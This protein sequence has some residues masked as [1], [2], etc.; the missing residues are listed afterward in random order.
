MKTVPY[1]Q[2][3]S[4]Y[5]L[6]QC[7]FVYFRYTFFYDFVYFKY[8]KCAWGNSKAAA[9]HCL[10]PPFMPDFIDMWGVYSMPN[11]SRI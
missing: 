11:S 2:C 3:L 8:M 5:K 6:R 4:A 1:E 10:P 9:V 7:N